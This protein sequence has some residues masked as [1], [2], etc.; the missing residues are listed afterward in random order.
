MATSATTSEKTRLEGRST[1]NAPQRPGGH[2]RW[3][4]CALLFVA[5]TINYIDRQVLALLAPTLGREIGWNERQYAAI[6]WSFTAAYALGFL[7]AGRIMDRFGTKRG[8]A[9]S[10]VVWSVAAH[11]TS[12]FP[13]A[14]F[15]LT[16]SRWSP[17]A[18]SG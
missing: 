14:A 11:R 10:I 18:L 8:L 9:G 4:I 17:W 1:F 5:T 6:V 7:F 2:Y 3:T 16:L 15:S 13:R 12:R